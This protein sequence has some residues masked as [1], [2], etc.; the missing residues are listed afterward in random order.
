MSIKLYRISDSHLP[1]QLTKSLDLIRRYQ[2]YRA[3]KELAKAMQDTFEIY[4]LPMQKSWIFEKVDC[5]HL[6]T[7]ESPIELTLKRMGSASLFEI[8]EPNP[9][10]REENNPKIIVE[11][12]H[13]YTLPEEKEKV[14]NNELDIWEDI[15]VAM[16]MQD[17]IKHFREV[18]FSSFLI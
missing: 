13:A 3:A 14:T 18:H 9:K 2:T 8:E 6:Y 17:H 10:S 5:L 1:R 11:C 4:E 12:R 15:P 7:P 16:K